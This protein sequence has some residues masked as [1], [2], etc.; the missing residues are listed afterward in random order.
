MGEIGRRRGITRGVLVGRVAAGAIAVG[1]VSIGAF[2]ISSAG[3]MTN[4][5]SK[6]VVISTVKNAKLG[7]I[8]VSGKT[9]YTLKASKTG[10]TSQCLKYWPEVTLPKGVKKAT[11]GKGVAASKLGSVMRS[12]GVRQVTY[13]GKALY[14]FKGD[15][16]AGQVHG[17]GA[18]DSW[19]TW[20]VVV[21][22][23]PAST[24]SSTTTTTTP[25]GGYGY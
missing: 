24:G 3:A 13:S 20:S 1:G 2:A 11:A 15:T 10:C 23:K 7:T 4:S 22:V 17:N 12:G 9:V 14:W 5:A 16:A 18:K 19:G 6:S 8:L 21:T 25:S